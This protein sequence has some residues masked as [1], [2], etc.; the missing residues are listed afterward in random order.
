MKRISWLVITVAM[1]L[2]A[3]NAYAKGKGATD[4]VTGEY[5]RG[6]CPEYACEP[7]GDALNSVAH[8]MVSA[9]EASDKRPQK[10]FMLSWTDEGKWWEVDL[11]DTDNS[12]VHVYEDGKARIGGLV[13]DQGG[14]N[15][16]SGPIG[17]YVGF[18]IEDWGEPA[19]WVDRT[20]THRMNFLR[21]GEHWDDYDEE[22]EY[23]YG[24]EAVRD[25]LLAWCANPYEE[26][27]P[28][29]WDEGYRVWPGIIF[30]GNLQVHN[31]PKDGD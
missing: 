30:E 22:E 16:G 24:W 2:L 4:K 18:H 12:C 17:R 29:T 15:P 19:Y 27:P 20:Q 8:R 21:I 26:E 23:Q 25:A 5:T 9:H 14:Y 1:C 31:S 28:F 7:P 6:N 3:A 11:S 13:S 10:G